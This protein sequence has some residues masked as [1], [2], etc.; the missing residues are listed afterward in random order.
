MREKISFGRIPVEV[1]LPSGSVLS[2]TKCRERIVVEREKKDVERLRHLADQIR[3][4]IL[5]MAIRALAGVDLE[6]VSQ[7]LRGRVG[8]PPVRSGYHY[9]VE[10]IGGARQARLY[11]GDALLA[12]GCTVE[13]FSYASEHHP[14]AMSVI[15]AEL[16]GGGTYVPLPRGATLDVVDALLA[17]RRCRAKCEGLNAITKLAQME[18]IEH[19]HVC[20]KFRAASHLEGEILVLGSGA[21]GGTHTIFDDPVTLVDPLIP[22]SGVSY[23]VHV[24]KR[25][26]EVDFGRFDVV[27]SDVAAGD[28]NGLKSGTT[29]TPPTDF[30]GAIY[31][32]LDLQNNRGP[33]GRVV[34]KPRP[35][36]S[37]VIWEVDKGG[38]SWESQ[39]KPLREAMVAANETRMRNFFDM[40]GTT[41][42]MPLAYGASRLDTIKHRPYR[43]PPISRLKNNIRDAE[44]WASP[45]A[46]KREARLDK[47]ATT[48]RNITQEQLS[49]DLLDPGPFCLLPYEALMP[50]GAARLDPSFGTVG[51][52][53]RSVLLSALHHGFSLA[54]TAAG[55]HLAREYHQAGHIAGAH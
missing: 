1:V 55:W 36:N 26:Q 35:H 2:N 31:V 54:R 51:F 34:R 39:L 33:P 29:F 40:I 25:W 38:T 10:D 27:I 17:Y 32:K 15:M 19:D 49:A 11:R 50:G 7:V 4:E 5:A 44:H 47:F 46:K 8:E 3:P 43:V 18:S 41:K 6:L 30:D 28:N 45:G 48:L 24:R 20:L 52:A 16:G 12:S 21:L 14:G 42:R 53:A 37:E 23:D 22:D 9:A 13:L